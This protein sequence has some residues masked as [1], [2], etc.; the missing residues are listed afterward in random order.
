LDV[1]EEKRFGLSS[2]AQVVVDDRVVHAV[3]IFSVRAR[4]GLHD[5][6]DELEYGQNRATAG[7]VGRPDFEGLGFGG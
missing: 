3:T 7:V 2:R 4:G 1:Q 5:D 6:G